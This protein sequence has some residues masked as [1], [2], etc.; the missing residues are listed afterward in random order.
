MHSR[1]FWQEVIIDSL[2]LS[3]SP[4]HKKVLVYPEPA[5]LTHRLPIPRRGYQALDGVRHGLYVLHRY[6]K[7]S[8]PVHHDLRHPTAARG[9]DR[10]AGRHA[11]DD[12]LPKWLGER[13]G[14]NQNVEVLDSLRD[15][16]DEACK[17]HIRGEV[18]LPAEVE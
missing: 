18:Q 13:R 1:K 4:F 2:D 3:R 5:I 14:V 16:L 10:L 15:I 9:D 17:L 12:D 11:L 6:E 8:Y 7:S